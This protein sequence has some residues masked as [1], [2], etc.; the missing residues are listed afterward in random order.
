MTSIR[1]VKVYNFFGQVLLWL[2]AVCFLSCKEENIQPAFVTCT[3]YSAPTD[4]WTYPILP[5]TVK[6]V[7][8]G[9]TEARWQACQIPDSHLQAMSNKAL[10]DAWLRFPFATDI[11]LYNDII[12]PVE[13]AINEFSGLREL[14]SRSDGTLTLFEEYKSRNPV[15]IQQ[16]DSLLKGDFSIEYGL[17]EG[18]LAN[19]MMLDKLSLADKKELVREALTKYYNKIE[20]GQENYGDIITAL[21]L[22]ICIRS[23]Y[24][25]DYEPFLNDL[26]KADSE[27]LISFFQTGRLFAKISPNDP[28]VQT[29]IYHSKKF[30]NN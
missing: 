19:D 3:P 21:S 2:F 22:F 4:A 10:L 30:Q 24:N 1:Q 15:C 25:A 16:M 8:L 5:G 12:F 13:F 14:S 9:S 17:L 18:L 23:M 11:F 27:V 26:K 6:W 29:I 28:V 20:V 7:E